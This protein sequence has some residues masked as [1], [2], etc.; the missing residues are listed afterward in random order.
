MSP[1][2]H[3]ALL[4]ATLAVAG[5]Q[6]HTRYGG[7]D[8]TVR[9][10]APAVVE[11]TVLEPA[12]QPAPDRATAPARSLGD[13]T[14]AV[15]TTLLGRPYRPGGCTA[16]G[17]FDCSGLVQ[18]VY[19]ELGVDVGRSSR[20]Q[21]RAGEPIDV[22]DARPG[23]VLVFAQAG[24]RGRVFHAGLVAAASPDSLVMLHANQ[25]HGVHLTRVDASAYWSG[26]LA[27]VRRVRRAGRLP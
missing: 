3:T 10:G 19:A 18:Y 7:A 27:G 26:R 13:S 21:A 23:D 12:G 25:R 8:G 22:G 16:E 14:L 2:R 20:D 6:L 9:E 5:L 4:V 17:G 24:G 15:A 11:P 1:R